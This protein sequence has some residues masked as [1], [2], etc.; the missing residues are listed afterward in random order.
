MFK[1]F[2]NYMLLILQMSVLEAA[3]LMEILNIDT[4]SNTISLNKNEKP[5]VK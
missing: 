5:T 2:K 4:F 1:Q 3:I